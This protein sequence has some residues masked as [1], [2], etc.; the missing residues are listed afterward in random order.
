MSERVTDEPP[1]QGSAARGSVFRGSL[2]G[3]PVLFA[4]VVLSAYALVGVA[5]GWMWHELWHATDGVVVQKQWYA[6]GEGLRQEFSGTGLYVLV[7]A[8]AG[9]LLGGLF[10]VVGGTR[11]VLTLALCA[12]G[13]MLAGWLM[14]KVGE[15]LG[16]PDPHELAKTADDGTR[17]PGAL[18]VSGLPPLLAFS[19]GSLA[20]LALV[21]TLFPEKSSEAGSGPEPRG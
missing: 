9:L 8:G 6:D 4:V 16:P 2:R 12:A 1:L 15:G 20:A 10:A 7:A 11:P 19:F 14:L 17:L 21:F 3:S 13:S 18:T 5:A